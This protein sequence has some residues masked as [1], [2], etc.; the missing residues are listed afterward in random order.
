MR[1]W[2]V[3]QEKVQVREDYTGR[4]GRRWK[5]KCERTDCGGRE[6]ERK[7]KRSKDREVKGKRRE[8]RN[9][10]VGCN[11]MEEGMGGENVEKGR[12][13]TLLELRSEIALSICLC[14]SLCVIPSSQRSFSSSIRNASMSTSSFSNIDWY[15]SSERFFRTLPAARTT[16]NYVKVCRHLQYYSNHYLNDS[17]REGRW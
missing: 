1:R 4:K 3:G 13:L 5:E 2:V 7:G 11:G 8:E 10:Q 14:E 16:Y 6:S 9:E 12:R 15:F 17:C